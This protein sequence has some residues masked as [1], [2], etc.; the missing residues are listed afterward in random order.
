M[1]LLI[2]FSSLFLSPLFSH[3]YYRIVFDK[4]IPSKL[5]HREK[6]TYTIQSQALPSSPPLS[7]ALSLSL[8]HLL[9]SL[10]LF[11]VLEQRL[12][13]PNRYHAA[14][15]RSQFIMFWSFFMC[16]H[17][18]YSIPITGTPEVEIVVR[19]AAERESDK[20]SKERERC[21]RKQGRGGARKGGENKSG[22]S[23]NLHSEDQAKYPSL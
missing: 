7:Q 17:I 9:F 22:H 15:L 2:S 3:P 18:L 10:R 5:R 23:D 12:P 8:S 6:T 20:A 14:T 11:S 13:T 16:L 4:K 1:L 21:A 19:S